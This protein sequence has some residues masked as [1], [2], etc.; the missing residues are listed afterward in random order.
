MIQNILEKLYI[1]PIIFLSLSLHE[2]CHG[3][4][5]YKLGDDTAKVMGRLTLNPFA[6]LDLLGTLAMMF[7]GFGWAK[8]VPVN[9]ANLKYKRLGP[10]LV[11]LAGP[12]SNLIFAFFCMVLG[13]ALIITGRGLSG[14][15]GS[16]ITTAIILNVTL[17]VFN[18][19]PVPPL[20]GSKVVISLLP[21]K[22]QYYVY[23]NEVYIQ[24][25]LFALLYLGVISPVINYLG[26][27]T[28]GIMIKL[29]GLII[30]LFI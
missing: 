4:A 7:F 20:D 2:M 14:F 3:Y 22:W 1:L 6:H 28:L 26:N 5:A 10:V 15:V 23:K 16:Y 24:I 21:Y 9:Y 25:V 29:A 11:A 30:N 13:I 19:L 8:P 12:L 17:A 18:M 27:F